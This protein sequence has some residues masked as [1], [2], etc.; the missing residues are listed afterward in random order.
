MSALKGY[1]VL[2]NAACMTGWGYGLVLAVQSLMATG[3][4]LAQVWAAAGTPVLVA[5]W[6]SC[7]AERGRAKTL[8]CS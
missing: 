6:A 1:L 8:G 4:D 5:Q 7:S 2:Y 3:G